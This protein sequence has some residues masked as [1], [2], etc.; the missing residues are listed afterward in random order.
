MPLL[1][2]AVELPTAGVAP[3]PAGVR[4]SDVEGAEE[5][6]ARLPVEIGGGALAVLSIVEVADG[7]PDDP[8]SLTT[9]AVGPVAISLPA[10]GCEP[11]TSTDE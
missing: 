4:T 2:N 8:S 1:D 9:E 11:S 5:V 10:G 7:V 6:G 3:A